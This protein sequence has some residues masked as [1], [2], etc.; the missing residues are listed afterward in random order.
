MSSLTLISTT[1]NRFSGSLPSN[2]FQTLPNLQS[3]EIEGNQIVG[4]AT[5]R[6]PYISDQ[7]KIALLTDLDPQ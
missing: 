4:S 6:I 1:D 3:F 7:F 2:M 5:T